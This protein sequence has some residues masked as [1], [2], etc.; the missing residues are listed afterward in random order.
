MRR[1]ALLLAGLGSL[2]MIAF[3]G[4]VMFMIVFDL[5]SANDLAEDMEW[6]ILATWLLS[7]VLLL[8]YGVMI[9]RNRSLHGR[10]AVWLL[11]LVCFPPITQLVY[12]VKHIQP[13]LRSPSA[14][15]VGMP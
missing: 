13:L 2:W 6:L 5:D 10:R 8:F 1:L 12:W 11:L 9:A 7:V 15:K 4:F 3:T 14:P